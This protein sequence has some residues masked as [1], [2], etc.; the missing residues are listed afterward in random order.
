MKKGM[1]II[2]IIIS[3]IAAA[4]AV[5]VIKGIIEAKKPSVK[6]DYYTDFTSSA[7]LLNSY[8]SPHCHH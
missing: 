4:V 1:K 3:V 8:W 5:L 6:E 7:P 2:G